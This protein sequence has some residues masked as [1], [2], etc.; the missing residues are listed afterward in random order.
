[1][2]LN[3][4]NSSPAKFSQIGRD[5]SVA[6][7]GST[8]PFTALQRE[9]DHLFEDFTRGWPV[10]GSMSELTP[11]IDL[12]ETDEEIEITAE[13]PGSAQA[14]KVLLR[15]DLGSDSEIEACPH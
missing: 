5:R 12:T 1:M 13:L 15:D 10:F 11:S 8:D 9:I 3:W 14:Q 4:G 6:R 7:G 2:C